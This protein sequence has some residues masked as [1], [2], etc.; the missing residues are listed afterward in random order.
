MSHPTRQFYEYRYFMKS[1]LLLS[2]PVLIRSSQKCRAT[3][4]GR[5]GDYTGG[6]S[7]TCVMLPT[8]WW[9]SPTRWE[10][11]MDS[12]SMSP[13]DSWTNCSSRKSCGVTRCCLPK[14][15]RFTTRDTRRL[16]FGPTTPLRL[17][18][19][20]YAT[21]TM[22]RRSWPTSDLGCWRC[23]LPQSPG[24]TSSNCKLQGT[25]T[26]LTTNGPAPVR[27]ATSTLRLI[28]LTP[29]VTTGLVFANPQKSSETLE[30]RLFAHGE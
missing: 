12:A 28:Q 13:W 10:E 22:T 6:R 7:Q 18:E 20:R 16:D 11:K 19:T 21:L 26:R 4:L 14:W 3:Y 25:W 30:G 23:H 2:S 15:R 8:C 1:L 27:L 24:S 17:P 5:S 29:S 9:L